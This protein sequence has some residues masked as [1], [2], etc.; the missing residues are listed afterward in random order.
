MSR[1]YCTRSASGSASSGKSPRSDSAPVPTPVSTASPTTVQ[2]SASDSDLEPLLSTIPRPQAP[3]QSKLPDHVLVSAIAPSRTFVDRLPKALLPIK[4]YLELI[5]IDKP[6]GTWLLYWPCGASAHDRQC[7]RS[8]S[9]RYVSLHS[10]VYHSVR[11]DHDSDAITLTS[12]LQS[13]TVP[14]RCPCHAGSRLH[15]QR[16]VGCPPG[17]S[18]RQDQEQAVSSGC[19]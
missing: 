3:L 6:I 14:D 12:A 16:H 8:Q 9:S 15:H 2:Q 17:S 13:R 7:R 4:P 5:R 11:L 19:R 18:S 1:G 10:L